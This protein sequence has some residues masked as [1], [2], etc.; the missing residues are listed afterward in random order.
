M[1]QAIDSRLATRDSRADARKGSGKCQQPGTHEKGH[2]S[3]RCCRAALIARHACNSN[4]NPAVE[5]LINTGSVASERCSLGAMGF[6]ER[7][8]TAPVPSAER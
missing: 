4:R 2:S 3:S 7:P 5:F 1:S 6:A 8:H